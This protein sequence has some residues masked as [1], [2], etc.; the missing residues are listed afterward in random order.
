[1]PLL[2]VA[3]HSSSIPSLSNP[4]QRQRS[5]IP[6]LSRAL[7][8]SSSPL[9]IYSIPVR[10]TACHSFSNAYLRQSFPLP[11]KSGR[12]FAVAFLNLSSRHCSLTNHVISFP[13]QLF[14]GQFF[15]PLNSSC[16][17]PRFSLLFHRFCYTVSFRCL[18]SPFVAVQSFSV[19][20]LFCSVPL[21]LKSCYCTTSSQVK[22][23]FP[24][25]RH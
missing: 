11:Y 19:A 3:P 23:P 18:S 25:F 8:F 20:S 6:V 2:R 9:L 14:A 4:T 13:L 10:F 5:Y 12:H 17:I 22:A 21:R 1:M 24:E 16:A 7:I 15:A